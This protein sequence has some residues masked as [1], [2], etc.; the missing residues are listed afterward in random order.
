MAELSPLAQ[1]EQDRLRRQA[2]RI[3]AKDDVAR[4]NIDLGPATAQAVLE[5]PSAETHTNEWG[6]MSRVEQAVNAIEGNWH[7]RQ[8]SQTYADF[9]EAVDAADAGYSAYTDDI[10]GTDDESRQAVANLLSKDTDANKQYKQQ[11]LDRARAAY[12]E[13]KALEAD[14]YQYHAPEDIQRMIEATK[15]KGFW[16][17]LG[18]GAKELLSGDVLGNAIYLSGSL[19]AI[20]PELALSA[21]GGAA[22]GAIG[23][24]RL[25]NAV[26]AAPMAYG[27]YQNSYGS[28]MAEMLKERGIDVG[29]FEATSKAMMERG[30]EVEDLKYRAN[31]Y[32]TGIALFDGL[33]GYASGLKLTPSELVRKASAS[34]RKRKSLAGRLGSELG[35]IGTQSGLQ[36]VLGGAGEAVGAL[37]AGEEVNASDVLLEMLGEFTTAPI[38]VLTAG[39]S[40]TSEYRRDMAKTAIAEAEGKLMEN[41]VAVSEATAV[42]LGNEET[43]AKWAQRLG[44]G[45]EVHAFAQDLV[46]NGQMEK[47][48]EVDPQLAEDIKK[49]AEEGTTLSMPV[50]KVAEIAVKDASLAQEIVKDCRLSVDGMSPRQ[51]EEFKKNGLEESTKLFDKELKRTKATV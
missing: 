12:D 8:K 4:G 5:T 10:D 34:A 42:A 33:A 6:N 22:G 20:A 46:V 23:G 50:G 15:G 40:T 9:V 26:R 1:V 13:Y 48:Q 35:N 36:G 16:E 45:K 29:E 27:S 24:G 17:G 47:L 51:A 39:V 28:K 49:A 43:V 38:E 19:G 7:N 31:N 41:I 25:A 18:I 32:A 2:R 21:I 11:Q 3:L 30:A 44:E 14:D 37:A